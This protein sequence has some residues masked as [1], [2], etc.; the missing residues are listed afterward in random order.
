[1]AE[2]KKKAAKKRADTYEPK[3]KKDLSFDELIAMSVG[4]SPGK[5]E[6]TVENSRE[7]YKKYSEAIE[8]YNNQ[9]DADKSALEPHITRL[10]D[11]WSDTVKQAKSKKKLAK[12]KSNGK[13]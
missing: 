5:K 2:A 3:L 7:A 10:K 9:S 11:N 12:K 4:K 1:M 6:T 8:E 13:H